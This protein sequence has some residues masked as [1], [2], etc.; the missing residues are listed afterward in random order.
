M[1]RGVVFGLG[2]AGRQFVGFLNGRPEDTARIVAAVDPSDAARQIAKSECGLAAF[3]SPDAA[4]ELRPDFVVV[5][6]TNAAHRDLVVAAAE[7][8]CHVFC[9]KPVALD[10][11]SADTMIDA[12]A[13]AGVISVVNY[14]MR[15]IEP[16]RRIKAMIDEGEL[17]RILSV[18]H[19]KVRGFGLAAGGTT[20]PAVA[21]PELSGGWTVHHACHDL[22]FLYW[23]LGPFESAYGLTG[24]SVEAPA[25]GR[26]EEVVE[27]LLRTRSGSIASIFDSVAIL[28]SH[29]T[30]VVGTKGSV[31][32]TGEHK[33]T[34]FL[35]RREAGP[36]SPE[37]V[38]L[39]GVDTKPAG[40]GLSHFVECLVNG[41]ESPHDMA[42][43]RHSLAAALALQE[44]AA[45][46]QVVPL[47]DPRRSDG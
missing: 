42:S 8:G 21:A 2:N 27:G 7:A 6:T 38:V 44:S 9:E 23:A 1:L 35:H 28:R 29:F 3:E 25:G 12:V 11:E 5:A 37:A 40:G 43:A 20:H 13:R 26:H 14:V 22:D 19:Q 36:A 33:N 30:R 15:F 18:S 24:S 4:L 41:T 47:N 46:G 39:P 45:T 16:Y 32:L 10:L 34:L 31:L 17:G